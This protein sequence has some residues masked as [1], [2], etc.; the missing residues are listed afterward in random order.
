M[1]VWLIPLRGLSFRCLPY[2]VQF[3]LGG[4]LW[5]QMD[6]YIIPLR[7]HRVPAKT[8]YQYLQ[9]EAPTIKPSYYKGGARFCDSFL[10]PPSLGGRKWTRT[11]DL[12][13]VREAL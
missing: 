5:A 1:P 12:F 6:S 3:I 4:I 7:D 9:Y 10:H 11:I 2:W 13:C 8:S